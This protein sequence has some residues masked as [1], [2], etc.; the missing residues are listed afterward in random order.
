MFTFKCDNEL[1]EFKVD[2]SFLCPDG[3]E[4]NLNNIYETNRY[5]ISNTFKDK[6]YCRCSD[7]FTNVRPR[8]FD[9][10]CKCFVCCKYY[11]KKLQ[12]KGGHRSKKFIFCGWSLPDE[13]TNDIGK[14][15]LMMEKF[16]EK[17]DNYI[18]KVYYCFEWRGTDSKGTPYGLH[19]HII[20]ESDEVRRINEK[21]KR[22]N[23]SKGSPFGFVFARNY[24]YNF[25]EDKV[26]YING[27]KFNEGGTLVKKTNYEN[28]KINRIKYDMATKNCDFCVTF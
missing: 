1:C 4:Y 14:M 16:L 25:F 19:C 22:W 12:Q 5:C 26:R 27:Y 24:T 20:I 11:T 15:K 13:N 10:K 7:K 6:I 8:C 2:K 21:I 18:K 28:D 17:L 3:C 23:K 9:G